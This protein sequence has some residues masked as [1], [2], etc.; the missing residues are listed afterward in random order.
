MSLVVSAADI[1]ADVDAYSKTRW[2]KA[3]PHDQQPPEM[4]TR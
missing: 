2:S 3:T 4:E 1:L